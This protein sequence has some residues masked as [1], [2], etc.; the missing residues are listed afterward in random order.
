MTFSG[1]GRRAAY[2]IACVA[3]AWAAITFV[4]DGFVWELGP[5]RVAS[6]EPLRPMLIGAAAAAWCLLRSVRADIDGDGEWLR[7]WL[8]RIAK[9]ATPLIVALGC[10]AGLFY[11]TFAAAGSDAYGYVSQAELWLRRD[12]LIEQP[13]VQQVSWPDAAW[14]FTPLGYRPVAALGTIAP[15]YP[16]GLPMMMAAFQGLFGRTAVFFVVPLLASVALVATYMLGMAATRSQSVSALAALL[17][18]ASPV[19]LA[20]AMVPMTDV[21]ATAGWALACMLALREPAPRPLLAGLAAGASILIRPNLILLSAVPILGWLLATREAREGM[22]PAVR[23]IGAF[24]GGVLPAL[25]VMAAIN[26]YMYGSVFESGYGRF[27]EIYGSHAVARN[28]RNYAAWLT[29]TQTLLVALALAPF[30]LRGSFRPSVAGSSPPAVLASLLALVMLSYVF[31]A[32]FDN[33][34]YLRF[35]LPAYPA[36]FVLMAAGVRALSARM[37]LAARPAVVMLFAAAAVSSAVQFAKDEQVFHWRDHE[38]R[39]VRAA[40]RASGL[41]PATAVLFSSQHS[42]SLR[43]HA[44][45]MTLRYDLL[46]PD[47]LDSAI[48]ELSALGRPSF[49]VI[50]DWERDVFRS[51]FSGSRAGGL[52]GQPLARVPGQPD[53]LIFDLR[54]RVE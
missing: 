44:D 31:Y 28:V 43:Y 26:L 40:A 8:G 2:V 22:R 13:I 1:I 27:D 42:G 52:E 10:A 46:P 12:L 25:I 47:R 33:W 34:T 3:P 48:R 45:R 20:H 16:P 49:L 15:T 17:L 53:V 35:L 9:L 5:L 6:T 18:L 41:T 14:T 21:P 24:L 32:P 23:R 50:D 29:Q 19:F 37:P 30:V 54:N 7:L 36:M 4:T 51:R 39:Y 11:G 38:Q